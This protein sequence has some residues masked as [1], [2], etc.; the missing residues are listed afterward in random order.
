MSLF[1]EDEIGI[2]EKRF[3]PYDITKLKMATDQEKLP[4]DIFKDEENKRISI[5]QIIDEP[6]FDK[7]INFKVITAEEIAYQDENEQ[8]NL[9]AESKNENVRF[10]RVK[11]KNC[12]Y[13]GFPAIALF[14]NDKTKKVRSLI[15]QIALQEERIKR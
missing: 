3:T 6:E 2:E 1:A 4:S 13:Q 14:I 8:A 7:P 12:L 9:L 11:T 5:K 15:D 10:V